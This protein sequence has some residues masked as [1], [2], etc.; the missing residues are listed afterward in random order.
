MA[1][2]LWQ[3]VTPDPQLVHD[4]PGPGAERGEL[5]AQLR[6]GL[7]AAVGTQVVAEEALRGA[8]N[9]AGHRVQRLDLAA[10]A[11]GGAGVEQAHLAEPGQQRVGCRSSAWPARR[12][13]RARAA[14][15]ADTSVSSAPPAASQAA[16]PPSSTATASWPSQR[17]SHQARAA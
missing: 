10:K 4:S 13:G 14:A 11:F 5:R 17:N 9:V 15:A 1:S 7:E 2:R 6:G 3:A 8:G 16:R 12:Q